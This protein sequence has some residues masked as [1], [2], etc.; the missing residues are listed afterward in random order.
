MV[1]RY[2]F[3]DVSKYLQPSKVLKQHK[4]KKMPKSQRNVFAETFHFISMVH[5]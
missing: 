5:M 4:Y 3:K 2:Y 1:G